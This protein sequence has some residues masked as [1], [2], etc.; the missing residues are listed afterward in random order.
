MAVGQF[1]PI[2]TNIDKKRGRGGRVLVVKQYQKL[3]RC[4]SRDV[5]IDEIEAFRVPSSILLYN[6]F[7]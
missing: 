5:I 1:R 7:T 6:D 3:T 4:D 2:N